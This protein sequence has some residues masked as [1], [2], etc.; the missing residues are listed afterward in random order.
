MNERLTAVA[1]Q[2]EYSSAMDAI[3]VHNLT[4]RYDETLA[5]DDISFT[6]PPARPSAC[7]VATAPARPPRSACCWAC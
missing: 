4:K 3:R 7:W 5:V 2:A 1:R 6:V